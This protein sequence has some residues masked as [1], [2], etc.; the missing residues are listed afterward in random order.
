MSWFGSTNP[1]LEALKAHNARL[2]FDATHYRDD[3]RQATVERHRREADE[4][5]KAEGE[6]LWALAYEEQAKGLRNQAEQR[7]R[8]DAEALQTRQ[9]SQPQAAARAARAAQAP[10]QVDKL[11]SELYVLYHPSQ[12]SVTPTAPS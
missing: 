10:R 3:S 11:D 7:A 6:E 5:R 8:T 1:E 4:R 12:Y 2:A 9:G